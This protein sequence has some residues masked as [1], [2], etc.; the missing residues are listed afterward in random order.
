MQGRL[1]LLANSRDP[2]LNDLVF[3]LL[4]E[5]ACRLGGV[6]RLSREALGRATRIVRLVEKYDKQRW[7]PVSANLMCRLVTHADERH[8]PDC[9]RELHRR[10]GCHL[11]GKWFERL[12]ASDSAGLLGRRT[13]VSA[14]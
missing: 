9:T 2:A 4:P 14:H 11:N 5:T 1:S 6:V 10:H 13:R 8:H 7:L 12:R 3:Q